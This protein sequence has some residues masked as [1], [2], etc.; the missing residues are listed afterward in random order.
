MSLGAEAL[1]REW[2][3]DMAIVTEPTDLRA[4]D[5]PQGL[6]VGRGRDAGPR[7]ARQPARRGPRRDRAHG[8]RAR[9]ARGAR[10]GAARAA[11]GRRSRARARCTRRS[12]QGGRELSSYPDRCTLAD[13]AAHGRRRGRARSSQRE[14]ED[15]LDQL[16]RADPEF[17]ADRAADGATA[18]RTALDGAPRAAARARRARSRAPAVPAEPDRHVVLDRRGDSRRRG[19]SVSA[20]RPRRRRASTA[21]ASTSTIDDVY[22]CRDVLVENGAIGHS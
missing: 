18:P 19:H 4:G 9:G 20:V 2:R 11:A 17:E 10:S 21:S 12:S 15:L 14:I 6:R 13:G 22:T 16:R 8:P 1:V 3:A 5:R 7:R